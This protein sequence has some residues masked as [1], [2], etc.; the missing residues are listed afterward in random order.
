MEETRICTKCETEKPLTEYNRDRKGRGGYAVQCRECRKVAHRQYYETHHTAILADFKARRDARTDTE[1]QQ[2]ADYQQGYYKTKR[3]HL[4]NYRRGWYQANR[5]RIRPEQNR[6]NARWRE[7]NPD[8][9]RDWGPRRRARARGAARIDRIDRVAIYERDNYTCYLCGRICDPN[10]PR[11]T[12]HKL[13]LDHVIPLARGGT[14]TA[15]NLRVACWSCNCSKGVSA[16]GPI[17]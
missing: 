5:G 8:K 16:P 1:K 13:T 11:A 15:D 4:S 12:P 3:T 17:G 10:A 6:V 7:N 14:H 2:D 9:V